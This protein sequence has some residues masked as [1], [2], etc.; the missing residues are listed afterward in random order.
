MLNKIIKMI[1]QDSENKI[2]IVSQRRPGESES[3]QNKRIEEMV[4]MSTQKPIKSDKKKLDTLLDTAITAIEKWKKECLS[5]GKNPICISEFVC[6]E[7]ENQSPCQD[8]YAIFG[9]Q[10]AVLV[11]L[12]YI[13]KLLDPSGGEN[14]LL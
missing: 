10:Q 8:K 5:Q 14:S 1:R 4:K 13:N 3:A 11:L 9:E 6:L 12:E 7:S 2:L